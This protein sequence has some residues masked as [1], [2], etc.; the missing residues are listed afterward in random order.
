MASNNEPDG[1]AW[2]MAAIIVYICSDPLRGLIILA[3][4]GAGITVDAFH[5][6]AAG[7]GIFLLAAGFFLGLRYWEQ[8]RRK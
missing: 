7:F 1:I 4:I 3:A 5:G 8:E 6:S 2:L